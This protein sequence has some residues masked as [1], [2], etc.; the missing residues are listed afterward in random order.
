MQKVS[1]MDM[2]DNK[3]KEEFEMMIVK[4]TIFL[5]LITAIY[6]WILKLFLQSNLKIRKKYENESLYP[7][8]IICVLLRIFSIIGILASAIYLLFVR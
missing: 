2:K 4:I 6:E 8:R 5:V 7:P 1:E 3:S